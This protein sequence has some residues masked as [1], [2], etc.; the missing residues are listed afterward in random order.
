MRFREPYH[1]LRSARRHAMAQ[2][3]VLK[4]VLIRDSQDSDRVALERLAALDSRRLTEGTF[5]LAE[6]AGEL[7][8][9]TTIVD[10]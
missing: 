7:R 10:G 2:P 4:A 5:L 6:L 1:L 9:E 8:E 3:N